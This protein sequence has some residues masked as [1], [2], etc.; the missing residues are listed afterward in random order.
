MNRAKAPG[1]SCVEQLEKIERLAPANFSKNQPVGPMPK[2][3]FEEISNTDGWQAVLWLSR[4][5]TDQIVLAHVNLGGVL[6]E[7][8]P[9]IGRNELPKNIEQRSLAGCGVVTAEKSEAFFEAELIFVLVFLGQIAP[10]ATDMPRKKVHR[11]LPGFFEG[12]QCAGCGDKLPQV[13]EWFPF[14]LLHEI[15]PAFEFRPCLSGA[16]ERC[17]KS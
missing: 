9:F 6:D 3:R 5:E 8:N 13:K 17:M 12:R 14:G 11:G 10:V 15:S 2:R 4:F 1:V 16:A 7:Q